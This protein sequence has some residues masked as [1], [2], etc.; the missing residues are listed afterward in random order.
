[1]SLAEG[2]SSWLVEEA[3]DRFTHFPSGEDRLLL[4][5]RNEERLAFPKSH[6]SLSTDFIALEEEVE[7]EQPIPANE[8]DEETADDPELGTLRLQELEVV[9]LT[10]PA[11]PKLY[12]LGGVGYLRS[13]N[14][15]SGV[16][17]VDDGLF[18]SSLT[19]LAVPYSSDTTS[20]FA[21]VGGGFVR[22]GEQSQFDYDRLNFNVGVRQQLFPQTYGELGWNNQQLFREDGGERFLNDHSVYFRLNRQDAIAPSLQLKTS[23]LFQLSFAEPDSRSQAIN[24]L[25]AGLEY[26][27][28]TSLQLGL[29]YQLSLADFTQRD[30]FDT[31]HQVLARLTYQLSPKARLELFGGRSFGGSSD[32]NIDFDG[33]IF[34]IGFGFLLY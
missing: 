14:I 9:P 16:D 15:L 32:A 23:Y 33:F 4:S 3:D 19:L 11:Q 24:T 7:L 34:G 29:D 1:M 20:V 12:L 8:P 13:N 21:S 25:S 31:Y 2:E 28:Y 5:N 17:P 27:P 10:P 26:S 6:L 30:R 22:Y 18:Q